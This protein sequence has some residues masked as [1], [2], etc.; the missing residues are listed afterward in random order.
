MNREGII[1]F[2]VVLGAI[3]VGLKFLCEMCALWWGKEGENKIRPSILNLW[4]RAADALPESIVLKPLGVLALFYDRLIGSIP[5]S[6]RA[7]WRT[8][9]ITAC[10]LVITTSIVGLQCGKP[11]GMGQYPWETYRLEQSFLESVAKNPEFDKGAAGLNIRENASDLSKARGWPFEAGYTIYFVVF[12][13]LNTALLNSICLAVSRLILKE[14]LG[15]KTTFAVSLMFAVNLMV[16]GAFLVIDSIVLFLGLN[17]A[18]WPFV[19]LLFQ[20]SQLSVVLGAGVVMGTT[21]A[22][23]FFTDPWF[24]VVVILSLIPSIFLALTLGGCVLGFPFR[25]LIKVLGTKFFERSLEYERGIFTYFATSALLLSALVA[26][27]VKVFSP[28]K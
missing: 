18:F 2:L 7:V 25:K 21:W 16:V 6:K 15:A 5:F 20:L 24:K 10:L 28:G 14:M 26:L 22:A 4:V 17:I 8:S 11:F 23:W 1:Y 9:V 3:F 13:L 27:L 19:P 12:V